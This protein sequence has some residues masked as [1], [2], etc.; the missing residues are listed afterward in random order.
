MNTKV[1]LSQYCTLATTG[2]SEMK[3][4]ANLSVG[5]NHDSDSGRIGDG[6]RKQS[7]AHREG[8]RKDEEHKKGHFC[9]QEHKDLER[10][11]STIIMAWSAEDAEDTGAT[12]PECSRE[13]FWL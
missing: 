5:L 9:H 4:L 7:P 2:L 6:I 8:E 3:L 12:I 11:V 13:S 10:E 1:I